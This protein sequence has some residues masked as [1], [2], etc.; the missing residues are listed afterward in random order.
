MKNLEIIYLCAL[1]YALG[2]KTYIT[3]LV[4]DFIIEQ[5]LSKQCKKMMIKEIE[6]CKDKGHKVD[7]E[8]WDKLLKHLKK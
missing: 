6:T 7:K 1:R 8:S 3:G 5:E 4:A 2:R